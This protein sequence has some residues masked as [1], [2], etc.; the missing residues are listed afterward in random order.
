MFILLEYIEFFKNLFRVIRN[1]KFLFMMNFKLVFV[2]VFLRFVF[3][4]RFGARD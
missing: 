2:Y 3:L 4:D 1:T